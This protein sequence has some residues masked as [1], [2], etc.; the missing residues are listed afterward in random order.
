MTH[1]LTQKQKLEQFPRI[2]AEKDRL[3]L[4]L[5]DVLNDRVTWGQWQADDQPGAKYRAGISRVSTQA[6]VIIAF[7]CQGQSD[8]VTVH[9][10]ERYETEMFRL[11][12]HC[13]SYQP[14]LNALLSARQAARNVQEVAA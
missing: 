11:R 5:S 2:Q 13:E 9:D 4:A 8:S 7:R 3:D 10:L 1:G 14:I 12:A 6:L